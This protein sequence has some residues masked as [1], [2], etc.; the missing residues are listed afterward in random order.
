[1][2]ANAVPKKLFNRTLHPKLAKATS[3]SLRFLIYVVRLNPCN[4]VER[5]LGLYPMR[6]IVS[7]TDASGFEISLKN[8]S[9]GCIAGFFD[10]PPGMSAFAFAIPW[11]TL[12]AF[13]P[14]SDELFQPHINY[15]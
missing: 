3:E 12:Y 15:L 2:L 10:A 4:Q 7:Y 14:T 8:P 1:M 5:F 9:P 6:R 13:L 11:A